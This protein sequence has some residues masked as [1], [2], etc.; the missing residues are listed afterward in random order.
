MDYRAK[1]WLGW[2]V[3][4]FLIATAVLIAVMAKV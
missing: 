2:G 1:S 4:A 3:V